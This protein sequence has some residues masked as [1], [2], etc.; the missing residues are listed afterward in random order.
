MQLQVDAE[1]LKRL[2]LIVA[3]MYIFLC[4]EKKKGNISEIFLEKKTS[5]Y[6]KIVGHI[7]N[8]LRMM[9]SMYV[10]RNY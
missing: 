4:I 1:E 5:V 6:F 3:Y 2:G 8:L 7:I 9:K 10:N